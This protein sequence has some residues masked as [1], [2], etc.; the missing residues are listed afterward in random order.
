MLG[1]YGSRHAVHVGVGLL[2]RDAIFQ[3]AQHRVLVAP[4]AGTEGVLWSEGERRKNVGRLR[5]ADGITEAAR[6]HADDLPRLAVDLQRAADSVRG[7]AEAMLPERIAQ[8]RA[9]ML[10]VDLI[11]ADKRPAERGADAQH[12]KELAGDAQSAHVLQAA[13]LVPHA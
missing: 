4:A 3:P 9:A 2:H 8:D 1:V 5:A 7:T 12:G 13:A 11:V 6:H 10:A